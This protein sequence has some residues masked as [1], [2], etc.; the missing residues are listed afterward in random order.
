MVREDRARL[1]G[2]KLCREVGERPAAGAHLCGLGVMGRRAPGGRLEA[3]QVWESP[4]CVCERAGANA[5]LCR[6][7]W[8]R[9]SC[10]AAQGGPATG[11][12]FGASGKEAGHATW[13]HLE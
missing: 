7:S 3:L 6:K 4:A 9:R 5:A 12:G 1:L 13:I 11:A 10:P 8:C 2:V